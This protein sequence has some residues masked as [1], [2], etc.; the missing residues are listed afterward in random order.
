VLGL[1]GTDLVLPAVPSLPAL[2]GGDIA[3][4]QLVIA[5]YAAGTAVGLI[6]YGV[7]GDHLPTRALFTGSLLAHALIAFA[8]TR[9][10][11]IDALIALRALQGAAAA[12]PAVFA[13]GIVRALFDDQRAMRAFGFLGSIEALAPAVAPI[14]G[15]WLLALAGWK[16]SFEVIA[17]LA[18]LIALSIWMAG[19]LPQTAR[20]ERGSYRALLRDA[21]F[22]RYALSQACVLGGLLTFVFG[23]PA[24]FVHAFGGHLSQFIVM[25]LCGIAGFMLMANFAGRL[26]PRHGPERLIS[27]GTGVACAGAI[28]TLVYA[29][30]GGR[31]PLLITALFVPVNAGLGVRG[32]P[33]F[34]RAVVA[35]RN[36]DARGAALV[37]LGILGAAALGTALAA[38]FVGS[39][40]VHLA[41][42]AAGFH[43]LAVLLLILLPKLD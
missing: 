36:D 18:V 35:A 26:L 6:A 7:L 32:P 28:A 31:D 16:L 19:S 9:V 23:M 14:I 37:I 3:H 10:D 41:A 25:Q 2:L 12:G 38:P 5:A 42:I 30:M 22:L 43:V 8:C 17:A 20:R 4:A 40:L 11:D 24:V 27:L 39:G 33:G 29:A 21:V 15:T 34:Y 1:A 13:P